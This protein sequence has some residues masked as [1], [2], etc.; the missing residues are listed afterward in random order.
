MGIEHTASA[1]LLASACGAAVA[2]VPET[3]ESKRYEVR[4]APGMSLLQAL[5]QA[6][7]IRPDGRP[8][9]G[10]TDWRVHWNYR[11]KVQADGLCALTTVNVRLTV[12]M[13][14]PDLKQSTPDGATQFA[15][16]YPA[17]VEHEEGHRRVGQGAARDVATALGELPPMYGC[18]LL[19]QEI[20]R[21]AGAVIER[22]KRENK[23]YDA[24]TQHGCTQGACL[25][26]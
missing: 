5:N 16:Y 17:L 14:L 2:E 12:T 24:R 1:L 21:T 22:A 8:F 13:T 3:F 15:N 7:P 19:E 11:Y 25:I 26:R 18:P 9:H 4:Q 6:T 23:A 10:Y 20:A